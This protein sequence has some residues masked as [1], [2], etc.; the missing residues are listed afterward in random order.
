MEEK[1]ISRNI[2]FSV[3]AVLLLVVVVAGATYAYFTATASTAKQEVKTGSLAMGFESGEFLRA[4]ALMPISDSEIKTK[5]AELDFSVTNEGTEHMNLTIS[6]TDIEISDDLKD[7]DFRWGLYNKDT[8]NGLA[9]GAFKDIGTSKSMVIYE[10]TIIDAVLD[11][12][13]E[14]ITKN[15]T[16]RVWIHDD[17]ANQNHM[18][19]ETFSAKVT[20]D[21]EPVKY[22]PEECFDFDSSTGTVSYYNA[23]NTVCPRDVIA[24]PRTIDGVEVTKLRNFMNCDGNCPDEIDPSSIILPNTVKTVAGETFTYYGYEH[25]ITIPEGVTHIDVFVGASNVY[26]PETVTSL[27]DGNRTFQECDISLIIIPGSVTT[28]N[29][30][31]LVYNYIETG[32]LDVILMDGVTTI[33]NDAF[34]D[35]DAYL[36]VEYPSSVTSVPLEFEGQD[37]LNDI[38]ELVVRGK[39]WSDVENNP[40]LAGIPSNAI[41]RP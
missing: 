27:G 8:G 34:I 26:I 19:G 13:E 35:N 31:F 29:K 28:I 1:K 20:V 16:L 23:E 33:A 7:V 22:A 9:F 5:A 41:F 2:I 30:G 36:R 12:N 25:T 6:L 17:G 18:Q 4:D 38:D 3:V 24:V 37:I 10:N 39:T 15:Y 14:D 32:V 21:G 40:S 11:E